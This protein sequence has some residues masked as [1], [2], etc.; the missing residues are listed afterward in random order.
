MLLRMKNFNI[1]GI[2]WKIW[3][4]GGCSQK[5]NIEGGLPNEEAGLGQFVDV[6]F[7]KK[8]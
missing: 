7:G 6:G 1:L 4:L 3:L 8:E 5:V 2:H